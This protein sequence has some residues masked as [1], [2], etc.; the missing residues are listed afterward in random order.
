MKRGTYERHCSNCAA[1]TLGERAG[2]GSC[3]TWRKDVAWSL[4]CDKWTARDA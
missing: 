4:V 1:Y 3:A 2:I